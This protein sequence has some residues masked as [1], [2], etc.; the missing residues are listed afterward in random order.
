MKKLFTFLILLIASTAFN[1]S[2]ADDSEPE[3]IEI[4][5]PKKKELG[6]PGLH[7]KPGYHSGI[8]FKLVNINLF[9]IFAVFIQSLYF[10]L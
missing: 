10:M 4:K 3:P 9:T 7:L 8:G 5:I 6:N 1:F 2:F